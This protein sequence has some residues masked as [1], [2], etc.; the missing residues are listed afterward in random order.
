MGKR[1][2]FL[3]GEQIGTNS[4]ESLHLY[5]RIVSFKKSGDVMYRWLTDLMEE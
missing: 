1:V 4:A 5:K 2:V 3:T